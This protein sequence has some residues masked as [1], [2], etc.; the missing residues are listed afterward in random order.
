MQLHIIHS[1]NTHDDFNNSIVT[2]LPLQQTYD[3]SVDEKDRLMK[4]MSLTA[5]RM[6]RA[7]K[8]TAALGDEQVLLT[9]YMP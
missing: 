5:A 3:D 4:Q 1:F 2:L 6:K 9:L 8:L 7:G